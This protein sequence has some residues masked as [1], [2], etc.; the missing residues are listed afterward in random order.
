MI[1]FD[2]TQRD[3]R[4]LNII[5]LLN[6]LPASD[7]KEVQ[8]IL[9]ELKELQE[10]LLAADNQ[11]VNYEARVNSILDVLLKYTLIDFSEQA[12]VS[13]AGDD[14]DAIAVGINTLAEELQDKI[15]KEVQNAERL[16]EQNVRL[17]SINKELAS[18]AYV[19]SHDLQEPLRKINTYISRILSEE[20]D[21]LSEQNRFY[22]ERIQTASSRMQK[23]IKDIL[24]YSKLNIKEAD[25]ELTD[26]TV[27]ASEAKDDFR[28]ALEEKQGEFVFDPLCKVR[29]IPFQ[30]RRLLNNLLSNSIKFSEPERPLKITISCRIEKGKGLGALKLAGSKNYCHLSY[31]DNGIGFEAGYNEKVFEVFQ[32]LHNQSD[33]QGTGVGLAIC[34]KIVENHGGAIT[35]SGRP[36]AGATFDIYLPA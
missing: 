15:E 20:S 6:S 29:I 27:L 2:K 10:Y 5:D 17:E 18:F 8:K 7:S 36:G 1:P 4:I 11:A 28:E 24:E 16:Q 14:L 32:R 3:L 26:L 34:K 31:T 22:F 9:E 35:A 23:L 33:Y 21:V 12:E 25:L 30:F 19:S 13:E